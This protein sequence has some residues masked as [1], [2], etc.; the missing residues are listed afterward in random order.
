VLLLTMLSVDKVSV[1]GVR[2]M[3][4]T[5]VALAATC[6]VTSAALG[7][8]VDVPTPVFVLLASVPF[9]MLYPL[10]ISAVAFGLARKVARQNRLLDELGHTDG[11]TGLGN[12]RQFLVLAEA[13]LE[14]HSRTGRPAALVVLDVD[15]FKTIND[16]Y[17][18]PVGDEVLCAVA[19]ILRRCCRSPDTPAR[20]GGDEFV[21]LLPETDESGAAEVAR[22]IR[23]QLDSLELANAPDLHCTVSL[24]AA[25][26]TRDI[27]GVDRWIERADAALYR[28]KAA[29]RDRFEG[30]ARD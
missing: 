3:A 22:R 9:L 29:G 20:F 8:P 26:A 23:S 21:L 5:F 16:R 25:E 11:L 1:G 12:R 27:T 4:R 7:F 28:A 19:E 17:G 2:L 10:A 13:E 18:H 6:A 24:G 30:A 15:H 14:R